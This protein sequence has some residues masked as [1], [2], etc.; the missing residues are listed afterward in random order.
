MPQH[1]CRPVYVVTADPGS[2]VMLPVSS[3]SDYLDVY[4]VLNSNPLIP[5][6]LVSSS[7]SSD[8]SQ[9]RAT[10]NAIIPTLFWIPNRIMDSFTVY[11]SP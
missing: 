9:H 5:P 2:E 4:T 3:Q 8:L 10:L 7:E 6:L 1:I 11:P